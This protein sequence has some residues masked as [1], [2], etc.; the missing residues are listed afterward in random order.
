KSVYITEFET[1]FAP[2]DS[3]QSVVK[4]SPNGLYL[5][6]GGQDG[7]VRIWQIVVPDESTEDSFKKAF[8]VNEVATLDGHTGCI[9]GIS[10]HSSNTKL[11]SC[12]KDGTC[13][14]WS[15][16][17]KGK[18]TQWKKCGKLGLAGELSIQTQ[19]KQSNRGKFI[20]RACHFH[21][22]SSDH[23]ELL[24]LQTPAR[25]SS[26]LTKWQY[27]SDTKSITELT[28]LV[29]KDTILCSMATN[30]RYIACGS[31]D[32]QLFLY[33]YRELLAIKTI[34]AHYLPSTGIAFLPRSQSSN[35]VEDND[36]DGEYHDELTILS[37]SADYSIYLISGISPSKTETCAFSESRI[38]P[39]HGTRLIR[40]DGTTH[41]LLN[42][43]C[44]SLFLQRKKPAKI[45]WTLGWRRMN[46]KL[47]VEE[48]TRRRARKTT[49]IQRAIVGVSVD[50]LKK[51]R[52][53]KPAVR[54]AARDAALKEA[55]DR[56]KAKKHDKTP[57][58]KAIKNAPKGN[59]K[60][61]G[62]RGA[63]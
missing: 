44:K 4:F 46:K 50:E 9:S 1:D 54:A 10:W 34:A 6:T 7:K 12:A 20:Y 38:Y 60:K 53:Q 13:F 36:K 29:I 57:V 52:N 42:S 27:S 21:E 26:Y 19:Q 31:S 45:V 59:L 63:I 39:G 51:K 61:G 8:K 23:F 49:K 41:I 25:G 40:K 58:N 35:N 37:G 33:S 3:H 28:S 48:V 5:A 43:K 55:K 62:N 24:T 2:D 11:L 56:S 15:L 14:L 17:K 47:R 32:G 18:K 22:L 16:D 30:L